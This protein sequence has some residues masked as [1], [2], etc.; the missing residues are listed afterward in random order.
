M[1]QLSALSE[2]THA[3]ARS[4]K[5]RNIVNEQDIR[6]LVQSACEARLRYFEGPERDAIERWALGAGRKHLIRELDAEPVDR[7]LPGDPPWLEAALRRGESAL[8]AIIHPEAQSEVEHIID[9]ALANPQRQLSK[10]SW[11]QAMEN[12]ARWDESLAKKGALEED[13]D[14]IEAVCEAL[15]FQPGARW[16]K[17]FSARALEREG[18]L[19]RHCVGSYAAQVSAGQCSIYSLRDQANHPIL[20]VE[21]ASPQSEEAPGSIQQARAAF[22]QPPQPEHASA[23]DA[24]FGALVSSGMT[25]SAG[26]HLSES[27]ALWDQPSQRLLLLCDLPE[28]GS[29][30]GASI[31]IGP[32]SGRLA[33]G[34]T[35]GRV[36]LGGAPDGGFPRQLNAREIVIEGREDYDLRQW[37]AKTLRTKSFFSSLQIDAIPEVHVGSLNQ[38]NSSYAL[39]IGALLSVKNAERARVVD[40][41]FKSAIVQARSI[42]LERLSALSASF[43][44]APGASD[45][46]AHDAKSDALWAQDCFFERL[47]IDAGERPLSAF[48]E[49]VDSAS[50][51]LLSES[52]SL[53]SLDCETHTAAAQTSP[54]LPTPSQPAEP[55]K[56]GALNPRPGQDHAVDLALSAL[57]SQLK[58]GPIRALSRDERRHLARLL[59][60][61]RAVDL[62]AELWPSGGGPIFLP[63]AMEDA[64]LIDYRRIASLSHWLCET[65]NPAPYRFDRRSRAGGMMDFNQLS[66]SERQS[67]LAF[68][69]L[70]QLPDL[71]P[72]SLPFLNLRSSP[73]ADLH[74]ALIIPKSLRE[75][76]VSH[77]RIEAGSGGSIEIPLAA[78][79]RLFFPPNTP[80]DRSEPR[81]ADDGLASRYSDALKPDYPASATIKRQRASLVKKGLSQEQLDDAIEWMKRL[82]LMSPRVKSSGSAENLPSVCYFLGEALAQSSARISPR[83]A[84]KAQEALRAPIALDARKPPAASALPS[85]IQSA[86]ISAAFLCHRLGQLAE[87]P[88]MARAAFA[89]WI[90]SQSGFNPRDPEDPA[91]AASRALAFET[92]ARAMLPD[93][94]FGAQARAAIE[95]R[96]REI[97]A[98]TPPS[99]GADSLLAKTALFL[100]PGDPQ[101]SRALLRAVEPMLESLSDERNAPLKALAQEAIRAH[102]LQDQPMAASLDPASIAE[103][104]RRKPLHGLMLAQE[105]GSRVGQS[106]ARL[107]QRMAE[108]ATDPMDKAIRVEMDSARPM[109]ALFTGPRQRALMQSFFKGFAASFFRTC[110]DPSHAICYKDPDFPVY[111]VRLKESFME[112]ICVALLGPRQENDTLY[113]AAYQ[114]AYGVSLSASS[115]PIGSAMPVPAPAPAEA[116]QARP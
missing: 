23:L 21:I 50:T 5:A 16:V 59:T 103:A 100:K 107:A 30:P 76:G 41:R 51:R 109:V 15:M 34:L 7:A 53:S 42:S 73:E 57:N 22:N 6:A 67:A 61:T 82:R 102:S 115:L 49:R 63:A 36:S 93:S 72:A 113:S 79:L 65:L 71:G 81:R 92:A 89:G 40:S 13:P 48:L 66:L 80:A 114:S 43:S 28:G 32:R 3:A 14:G 60:P 12:T 55:V 105:L 83:T 1:P 74:S 78:C 96:C 10:L 77:H 95:S 84:Q 101:E 26:T 106:A 116:R 99:P 11:A 27:G 88:A 69:P 20:T 56:L 111:G 98:K 104:L 46:P 68:E 35:F 33:E 8:R 91:Q 70:S 85:K 108:G 75:L 9:W 39:P 52:I 110:A 19:M 24:L 2:L 38:K 64:A 86:L 29:Y 90:S 47:E 31:S 58:V 37:S 62:S 87:N 54:A 94:C 44:G 25:L 4:L 17:V 97:D 112:R 18:A 45:A